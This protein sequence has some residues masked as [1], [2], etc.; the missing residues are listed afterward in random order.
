M[1]NVEAENGDPHGLVEA[2][3][4]ILREGW[5]QSSGWTPE[6]TGSTDRPHDDQ[7]VTV[8]LNGAQWT[9]VISCLDRW[10]NVE[11]SLSENTATELLLIRELVISQ[12][13]ACLP[14]QL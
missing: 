4:Q 1:V 6:T 2:G 3:V 11:R 14:G 8:S 9:Y 12:G 10:G 5:R 7:E 13:E